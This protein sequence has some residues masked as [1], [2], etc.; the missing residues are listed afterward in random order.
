ME[1]KPSKDPQRPSLRPRTPGE[2]YEPAYE[3]ARQ[4]LRGLQ[5]LAAAVHASALYEAQSDDHGEFT[6][7]F[8]GN[9]YHVRWPTGTV[10]QEG[11]QEEAD[12]T[13]AILLLHY[14]VT[15]DG[16]PFGD[17]WIAFRNLPGGMGYDAAFQGRAN[18]RLAHA[19]GTDLSSF[20][21]ACRKLRGERLSFGDASFAF[22]VL[23][24][25]WLAVV[26]YLADE[27]FP[28]SANVL[29]D[30]AASHYLSTEDLAVLGGMLA[31]RL[32]KATRAR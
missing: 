19:F 15:A 7:A 8:F 32:I 29:F 18:L 21:G 25:L 2:T 13:T 23:P 12:I 27:E 20:E 4:D 31:S 28:A 11:A 10:R 30:G 9:P 6:F 5:P 3:K 17:K 26:L 22:R 14:L 24:R 16:A 1:Q